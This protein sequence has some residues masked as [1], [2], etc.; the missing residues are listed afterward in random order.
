MFCPR[1]AGEPWALGGEWQ[2]RD[3]SM[4]QR[5]CISLIDLFIHPR[6]H[7][8]ACAPLHWW[9]RKRARWSQM[10]KSSRVGPPSDGDGDWGPSKCGLGI[11]ASRRSGESG[12]WQTRPCPQRG[13]TCLIH[14]RLPR[15]AGI[16]DAY[17]GSK[18]SYRRHGHFWVL[19]LL[20]SVPLSAMGRARAKA[21][22]GG[23]AQADRSALRANWA[24]GSWP[25]GRG[26]VPAGPSWADVV[27]PHT[28]PG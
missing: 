20:Q 18:T 24:T 19:Q 13:N 2:P 23:C 21:G 28:S 11:L 9:G 17:N 5:L 4:G 25:G 16:L 27:P 15:Q 14:G 10:R 8:Q 6:I 7:R 12:R 1:P 22:T 3:Q 26:D